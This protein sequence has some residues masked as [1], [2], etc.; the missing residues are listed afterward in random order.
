[1]D[2]DRVIATIIFQLSS[3]K[4]RNKIQ[5]VQNSCAHGILWFNL[6]SLAYTDMVSEHGDRKV[7]RESYSRYETTPSHVM[8]GH[9]LVDLDHV[10]T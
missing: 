8:I 6:T 1:M 5:R 4:E 7:E 2:L 3:L 10:I 9:G